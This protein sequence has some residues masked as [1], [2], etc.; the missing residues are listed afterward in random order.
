MFP[1]ERQSPFDRRLEEKGVDGTA[2][3]MAHIWGGSRIK[4]VEAEIADFCRGM[5]GTVCACVGVCM[6]KQQEVRSLL[7]WSRDDHL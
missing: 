1:S 2:N 3:V 5:G 4:T 7:T 6:Q